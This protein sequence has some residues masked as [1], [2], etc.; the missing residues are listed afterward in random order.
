MQLRRLGGDLQSAQIPAS[1][2]DAA[3]CE[4]N[5]GVGTIQ[6]RYTSVKGWELRVSERLAYVGRIRYRN[7]DSKR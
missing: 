1:R 6:H 4:P 5:I 3:T 7:D 2:R